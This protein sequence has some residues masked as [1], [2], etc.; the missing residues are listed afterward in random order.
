MELWMWRLAVV[1]AGVLVLAGCVSGDAGQN[2]RGDARTTKSKG[3]PVQAVAAA[4]AFA[5]HNDPEVAVVDGYA[6]LAL[7]VQR[8]EQPIDLTGGHANPCARPPADRF[9]ASERAAIKA[10]F[11]GRTVSFVGD[12]A[13]G[14]REREPGSL[15]LVASRPLLG[16]QRGTVMVLSCV[17]DPQQVLVTVQWDGHVCRATATGAGRR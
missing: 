9:T 2:A 3:T 16:D 13:A 5:A 7:A 6:T 15:L 4:L 8:G 10:A 11:H 17:P 12:P 1:V 14:L